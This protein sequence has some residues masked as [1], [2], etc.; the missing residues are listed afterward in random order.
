MDP[1]LE[2]LPTIDDTLGHDDKI[3]QD[4]LLT[5]IFEPAEG[6]LV[7]A[8]ARHKLIIVLFAAVFAA[9]GVGFGHSRS[10]TYTAAAT[11]QVG[12]V[13]PNSPGFLGYVQSSSS[14]A[15]AFSRAVESAPVLAKIDKTLKLS[16]EQAAPRLSSAPIPLSP[17]FR[18]I[19]TGPSSTSAIQLA[20]VAAGAVIS[21]E[22]SANSTNPEAHSLLK[23]YREATL[24]VQKAQSEVANLPGH[25]NMTKRLK[26]EA[27]R[28]AAK[29]RR[30]AIARAYEAAVTSQAPRE[31]LVS[32]LAGATSS[33]NN[34]KSKME[35]Y[36]F[37]GL[38]LGVVAGCGVAIMLGRR[39]TRRSL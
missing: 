13:N 3:G 11:L 5:G 27:A 19:A 37:L 8:I 4:H 17:A 26:A 36:G 33:T 28:D 29:E 35:L 31:G 7:R 14:L 16:P 10:T 38:L 6:S 18:V 25:Q 22:S 15:T 2:T 34:H 30:D 24:S 32:L 9:L 1:T 23:E 21:Y 12:Q 39:R 20:N